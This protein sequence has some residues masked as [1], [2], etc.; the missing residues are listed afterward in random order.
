MIVLASSA[1]PHSV[2]VNGLCHIL[3]FNLHPPMF[4]AWPMYMSQFWITTPCWRLRATTRMAC[5]AVGESVDE[6][7]G[8]TFSDCG[9]PLDFTFG[10]SGMV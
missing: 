8:R 6:G 4:I 1:L 7:I 2:I 10:V 9:I 5:V 3:F